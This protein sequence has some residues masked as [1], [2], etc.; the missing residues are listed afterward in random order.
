MSILYVHELNKDKADLKDVFIKTHLLKSIRKYVESRI[1]HKRQRMHN[2]TRW[3]SES[4]LKQ[5]VLD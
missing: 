5:F 1:F 2:P 4:K 3:K